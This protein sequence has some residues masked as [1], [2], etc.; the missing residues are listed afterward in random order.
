MVWRADP[1]C[2]VV[3]NRFIARIAGSNAGEGMGVRLCV[4]RVF[5]IC[6]DLCE[7]QITLLEESYRLCVI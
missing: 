5:C 2:R 6:S 7:E 4:C 3:S 1:A